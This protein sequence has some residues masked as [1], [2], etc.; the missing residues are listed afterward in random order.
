LKETIEDG[1]YQVMRDD[2]TKCYIF[3]IKTNEENGAQVIA[4]ARKFGS[5]DYYKFG[6]IENGGIRQTNRWK[7]K[8]YN[9]LVMEAT[10]VLFDREAAHEAGKLYARSFGRCYVCNRPLTDPHS[11]AAG[12]GPDCAGTRS[13]R[14]L[15]LMENE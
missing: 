9:T 3:R 14:E 6:L 12:I 15:S 5:R 1:F 8:D 7:D 4:K 11:T 2:G 10:D 13:Q